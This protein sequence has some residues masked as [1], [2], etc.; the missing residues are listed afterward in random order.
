MRFKKLLAQKKNR[1]IGIKFFVT[2]SNFL[3]PKS[4]QPAGIHRC[5]LKLRLFDL[6]EFIV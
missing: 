1:K 2:D 5:Y 6:T 4:L 3:I